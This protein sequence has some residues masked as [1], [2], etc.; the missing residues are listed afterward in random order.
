MPTLTPST[1]SSAED[2]LRSLCGMFRPAF[3]CGSLER[4][5]RGEIWDSVR[6]PVKHLRDRPQKEPS[7][8]GL[9]LWSLFY[10]VLGGNYFLEDLEVA[11]SLTAEEIYE[12][13]LRVYRHELVSQHLAIIIARDSSHRG[14][15]YSNA[16]GRTLP[17]QSLA[18]QVVAGNILRGLEPLDPHMQVV[19][20][21][22][23]SYLDRVHAGEV[24]DS[25]AMI[26]DIRTT[27]SLLSCGSAPLLVA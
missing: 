23:R 24:V 21:G 16:V 18:V 13:L 22:L 9:I 14:E 27:L 8:L 25:D 6:V 11:Q 1:L 20:P 3:E 2:A 19:G 5:L 17:T 7:K 15:F 12:S 4:G 26:G 10:D